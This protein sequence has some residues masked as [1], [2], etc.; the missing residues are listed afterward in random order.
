MTSPKPA[1]T[2]GEAVD[3]FLATIKTPETRRKRAYALGQL[4]ARFQPETPL[5]SIDPADVADWMQ[6]EWGQLSAGTWNIYTAAVRAA[7]KWWADRRWVSR[8]NLADALATIKRVKDRAELPAEILTSDEMRALLAQPSRRYPTGIRNRAILMMLYRSGLRLGELLALMPKDLDHGK[9]SIRVLDTKTGEPQTRYWHETA[10]D[11]L[12]RWEDVRQRLGINGRHTLFCSLKGTPL[13]PSYV[14][15]MVR[16]EAASAGI[17]KRVH[18]HA[19]RHTFAVE[20]EASGMTMTEISML[21]GHSGS[22][23]T[24]RYLRHLSSAQAGKAL[25]AAELPGAGS[26][27]TS[28]GDKDRIARLEEQV[29]QLLAERQQ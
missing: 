16:R 25:A 1:P 8:D 9:R 14:R 10:D 22:N 3:R 2:L 12:R 27:T 24:S 17:G 4:T 5:D 7:W 29:R 26:C 13:A 19:L 21:L 11:T 18:P 28:G 23:V 6:D 20:L 15:D